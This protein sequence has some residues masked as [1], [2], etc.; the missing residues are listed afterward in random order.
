M[1]KFSYG[2]H[3]VDYLNFVLLHYFAFRSVLNLMHPPQNP[4][5]LQTNHFLLHYFVIL[6]AQLHDMTILIDPHC[7]L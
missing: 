7:Y 1:I 3:S 6:P 4:R 2:L 5:K